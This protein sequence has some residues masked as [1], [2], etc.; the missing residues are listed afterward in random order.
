[1]QNVLQ[2]TYRFPAG[3][4][5][6]LQNPCRTPAGMLQGVLQRFA[7]P[8]GGSHDPVDP[9]KVLNLTVQGCTGVAARPH[10]MCCMCTALV[11]SGF[12]FEPSLIYIENKQISG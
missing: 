10:C 1:M 6:N 11:V 4:W 9:A 2:G 3:R 7:E 12:P 8:A 5:Q